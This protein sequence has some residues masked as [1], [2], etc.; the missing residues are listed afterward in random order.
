MSGDRRS[1]LIENAFAAFEARDA[2]AVVAFLA[3]EVRCRVLPPLM[4]TGEWHGYGGFLEMTAGWEEAFGEIAYAVTGIELPDDRN[5]L[6]AVHQSAT[7]AGSGVPVELD[8]Y[9]LIEFEG[10]RAARLE[11]HPDRDSALAA[12]AE[13]G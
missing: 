2:E 13:A 10:D 3:P 12:A 11:I 9:F 7:G 6:V 4:N 5:A 8:V 1:E